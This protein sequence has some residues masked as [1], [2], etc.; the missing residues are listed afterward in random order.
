MSQHAPSPEKQFTEAEPAAIHTAAGRSGIGA[1]GE[2]VSFDMVAGSMDNNPPASPAA[3]APRTCDATTSSLALPDIPGVKI[4]ALGVSVNPEAAITPEACH[5]LMSVALS[6]HRASNW[7]LGDAL[8]LCE[9][10]W[11]NRH[12]ESKYE[13][14]AAATGL[15][16]ATLMGIAATCRAFPH[17]KRHNG[18]SFSH[19]LETV[20]SAST[21]DKRE[22]ALKLAEESRMSCR[23]LRKHLRAGEQ[24][25][26]TTDEKRATTGEND[27]RPF[28]LV[29][30]PT[31]EEAANALP[32]AYELSKSA[33]WLE[34]HP[35][36][37]LSEE[38]KTAL[39]ERLLPLIAYAKTLNIV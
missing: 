13:E 30:L 36:D 6:M 23:D 29:E 21:A 15:S 39:A 32:I 24:A 3:T 37:T 22:A 33:C 7:V 17:D 1:G 14:A 10:A 16:K 25:A 9:R 2:A 38:H 35:A 26:M 20:H 28:G 34:A 19:H 27:D 31:K 4:T 11:G 12:V 8:L 5:T 18:L